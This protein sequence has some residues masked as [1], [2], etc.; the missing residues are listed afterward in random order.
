M[1]GVGRASAAVT[2][3]NA[4]PT[5]VGA[6]LGIDLAA[7][8]EVV[9]RPTRRLH[10][11]TFD[12]PG[13][14]RT[15]LVEEALRA[16]VARFLPTATLDATLAVRSEIPV[17][18]GLKSSSAVACAVLS[19]VAQAAHATATPVDIARLS[20]EV[21]RE[22]GVS[23]T[24]AFDDAL[25]GLVSGF[26]LTDNE[27]ATVLRQ[28][29]VEPEWMVALLVPPTSH[30]PSPEWLPAFRAR[31]ADGVAAVAAAREGNW[32]AAM[33]RNTVLVEEVMGYDY[34]ELRG[35]LRSAGAI[36]TGVS[37]LGPTLAAVA[38]RERID[39]VL[40]ELPQAR[41]ERRRVEIGSPAAAAP[42]GP[43]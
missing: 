32:W 9:L 7:T 37:G 21:S 1:R 5:G 22:V 42:G 26:V 27:R 12:I 2:L 19:A 3:V 24:G 18:R 6:A 29:P 33:E 30:R 16:G 15:P 10:R 23:A 8:A 41:G 36:A 4:L 20:A 38:P 11:P 35:R 14:V 17:A 28:D 39:A 34:S 43:S 25:A 40:E 13:E 31:A